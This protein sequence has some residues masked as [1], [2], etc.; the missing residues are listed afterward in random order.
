MKK[1]FE[2]KRKIEQKM[3]ILALEM[4]ENSLDS[5]CVWA[6]HQPKLSQEVKDALKC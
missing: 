3:N 1:T 5:T 4:A 6:I 2:T